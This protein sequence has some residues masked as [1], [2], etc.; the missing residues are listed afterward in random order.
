MWTECGSPDPLF[1]RTH[2]HGDLTYY[3]AYK[4]NFKCKFFSE[5]SFVELNIYYSVVRMSVSMMVFVSEQSKV[6]F[7][8]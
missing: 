2:S 7:F 1:H 6:T 3:G 4:D 8:N 5:V